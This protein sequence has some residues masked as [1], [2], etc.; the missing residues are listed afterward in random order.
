L[1]SNTIKR[2]KKQVQNKLTENKL[3]REKSLN[4]KKNPV[5]SQKKQEFMGVRN[6]L[7][8]KYYG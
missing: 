5:E 3:Q 4:K 7:Y 6:E 2:A 1:K 8:Q